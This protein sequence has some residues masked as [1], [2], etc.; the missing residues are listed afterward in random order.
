V[1]YGWDIVGVFQPARES[2]DFPDRDRKGVPSAKLRPEYA[3]SGAAVC[4]LTTDTAFQ[5]EFVLRRRR[6]VAAS[7]V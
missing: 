5:R 1:L 7:P 4:V 6:R 2:T 3:A